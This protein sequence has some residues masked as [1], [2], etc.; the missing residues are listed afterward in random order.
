MIF[1]PVEP[2]SLCGGRIVLQGLF[3]K[4]QRE[5]SAE[6]GRIVADNVLASRNLVPAI[7]RGK[8]STAL[9]EILHRHVHAS[10]DKFAGVARPLVR[11]LS[12]YDQCKRAVGERVIDS[13]TDSMMHVERYLDSAMD[14]ENLLTSRMQKLPPTDFEQ[15]LHP[16]F[17][18]DEWKL[19]LMGGVLGVVVGFAQWYA[20]GS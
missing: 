10:M 3:L 12:K 18:A 11:L 13:L 17:K 16:V 8:R 1:E 5:V 4:R 6:Y 9:F 20:L 15:L 2:I 19:V 14:L 7:I